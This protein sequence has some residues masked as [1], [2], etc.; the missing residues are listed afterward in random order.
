MITNRDRWGDNPDRRRIEAAPHA[1]AAVLDTRMLDL[2]HADHGGGSAARNVAPDAA[3][4]GHARPAAAGARGRA[5]P[6][7]GR[8]P[9]EPRSCRGTP[10]PGPGG[11]GASPGPGPWRAAPG[12]PPVRR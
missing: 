10:G 6:G 7:P 5:G 2:A 1:L 3:V 9:P 8:G 4:P 12:A 11:G